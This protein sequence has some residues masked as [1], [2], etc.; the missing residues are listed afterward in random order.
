[1]ENNEIE[2]KRAA[3][4]A[5]TIKEQLPHFAPTDGVC[6]NCGKQIYTGISLEK[7]STQLITGC[8]HCHR[9]YCD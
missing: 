6:W 7:A 5:Y 8:P 2:E 9:S 1:M 3:Q 4:K